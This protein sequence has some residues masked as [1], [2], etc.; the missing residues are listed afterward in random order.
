MIFVET[1][2]NPTLKITDLKKLASLGKKN[3]VLTVVDNTFASP[4]LQNPLRFGCDLVVHSLTK[5]ISGHSDALGGAVIGRKKLMSQLRLTIFATGAILDPFAAFLILRGLKTLPLRIEKHCEN[6]MAVAKFLQKHKRV[7]KVY[8]PGLK[9]HPQHN[10][11]KK[12]MGDFGGI[13]AFELRGDYEVGK[14]LM[15]KVKLCRLAVSLGAVETLIEHPASMTHAI[16]SKEAR[17]EAG[18]SDGLVRLSVGLEDV[19][20]II[21]DLK[22]ALV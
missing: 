12:Q 19:K 7:E 22:Q 4:Y 2:A 21:A 11:V 17:G 6:A 16:M 15:K 5:Y 20:D 10:L 14:R 18:I 9:F 3:K 1:P 13:L 8:Y